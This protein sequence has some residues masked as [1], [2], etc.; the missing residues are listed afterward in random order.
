MKRLTKEWVQKADN[1]LVVAKKIADASPPLHE[2]VCFHW[3]QCAEKYL[4]ALLQEAGEP[5]PRTHELV[6]LLSLVAPH[7]R[8]AG[9]M[10]GLKFLTNFAVEV[11]YPP[12]RATKRQAAAALRWAGKVRDACCPLLGLRPPR[13]RK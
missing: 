2:A 12:E 7:Y 8:V 6:T 13:R 11:R 5:V 3:Q 4:K 9:L 10:R 1:D